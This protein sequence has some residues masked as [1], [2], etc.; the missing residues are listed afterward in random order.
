MSDWQCE[1]CG[2]Q[3]RCWESFEGEIEQLKENVTL[4]DGVVKLCKD[5][6]AVNVILKDGEVTKDMLREKIIHA[7]KEH[8]AK[9]GKA[10]IYSV[11]LSIGHSTRLNKEM[12]PQSILAL[13]EKKTSYEKLMVR[14]PKGGKN[15][16]I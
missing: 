8:D 9:K 2:Y 10:G 3:E 4:N 1:Y 16:G 14:E 13:A 5:Y 15:N 11:T 7:M 12:I 6:L